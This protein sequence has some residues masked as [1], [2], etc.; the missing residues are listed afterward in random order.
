MS[1]GQLLCENPDMYG[2]CN[3][4]R[5]DAVLIVASSVSR[6]R[7][8]FKL[9]IK[10]Y[11]KPQEFPWSHHSLITIPIHPQPPVVHD[12]LVIIARFSSALPAVRLSYI[13]IWLPW[14]LPKFR[15]R[16]EHREMSVGWSQ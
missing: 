2:I 5:I 3:L 10:I 7:R 16:R 4:N 11:P 15:Y 6:N 12:H 14:S 13:P 8:L 1:Q 9:G